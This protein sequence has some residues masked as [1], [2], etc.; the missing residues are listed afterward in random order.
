M[1]I[2]A[3]FKLELKPTLGEGPI[4]LH[5]GAADAEG[6][7]NLGFGQADEESQ[8]DDA[9]LTRVDLFQPV[10]RLVDGDDVG[11]GVSGSGE[12]F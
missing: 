5:R 6:L 3:R 11:V 12:V 1:G 9:G 7:G 4:A 2:L 10:E 8:L